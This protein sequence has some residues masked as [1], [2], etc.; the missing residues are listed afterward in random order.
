MVDL[1]YFIQTIRAVYIQYLDRLHEKCLNR[2]IFF[3]Y[4]CKK[5]ANPGLKII[6]FDHVR[7]PEKDLKK[8][9]VI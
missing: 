3:T 9:Y 1:A 5:N 4:L 2:H 7:P 8:K 6:G